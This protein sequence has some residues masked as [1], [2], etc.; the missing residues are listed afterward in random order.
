[1]SMTVDLDGSQIQRQVQSVSISRRVGEVAEAHV[2]Y[3]FE[4]T[5]DPVPD[6]QELIGKTLTVQVDPMLGPLQGGGSTVFKGKVTDAEVEF[7][8]PDRLTVQIIAADGPLGSSPGHQSDGAWLSFEKGK[9]LADVAQT[10]LERCGFQSVSFAQKVSD[11][12]PAHLVCP[13][14]S[15]WLFL[16]TLLHSHAV[17]LAMRP[18]TSG[19]LKFALAR[20][21]SE[22]SQL[23]AA[24]KVSVGKGS[25]ALSR[26]TATTVMVHRA[27]AP[28]NAPS[29]PW[30]DSAKEKRGTA[31]NKKRLTAGA[32][33]TGEQLAS[34]LQEWRAVKDQGLA[35][36]VTI[37]SNDPTLGIGD[38]LSLS[39]SLNPESAGW[40]SG[41]LDNLYVRGSHLELNH[42]GECH[43]SLDLI[44]GDSPVVIWQQQAMAATEG[45]VLVTGTVTDMPPEQGKMEVE[46]DVDDPGGEKT[47]VFCEWLSP[48]FSGDGGG[49]SMPPIK[50]D[51]V[52]LLLEVHPYGR[53]VYLGAVAGDD[54]MKKL[55]DAVAQTYEANRPA[56]RD[57][58]APPA[59][60]LVGTHLARV[61]AASPKNLTAWVSPKSGM[62]DDD[63]PE[64]ALR[65][66]VV[67]G[68]S[69]LVAEVVRN[70]LT[71][72]DV[73]GSSSQCEERVDGLHLTQTTKDTEFVTATTFRLTSDETNL[74]ASNQLVSEAQS[75]TSMHSDKVSINADSK[76][77]ATSSEVAVSGSS[78]TDIKGGVVNVNC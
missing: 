58:S 34:K 72:R 39:G 71:V 17:A 15:P 60:K 25:E 36:A 64:K 21:G 43:N 78:K 54:R 56:P 73:H 3:S 31:G 30:W 18:D 26:S 48:C 12:L 19:E 47:K 10:L 9:S 38:K 67:A 62:G 68:Q 74:K 37:V 29:I 53:V 75:K 13:G 5:T 28:E 50:D 44:Y 14:V 52:R 55:R 1:M 66:S 57:G 49:L 27:A 11:S 59:V 33:V 77:E 46:L 22:I 70:D 63:P 45:S 2:H 40:L 16:Q 6:P 76:F 20:K 69:A 7:W 51:R 23:G 8:P 32:P 41:A 24:C 61:V 42:S 35:K 4:N 65:W